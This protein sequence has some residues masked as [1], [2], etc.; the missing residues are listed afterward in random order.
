MAAFL[1]AVATSANRPPFMDV[2]I[3]GPDAAAVDAVSA[4]GHH[5]LAPLGWTVRGAAD[6]TVALC[7]ADV[8]VH[9]I[10]YGDLRGREDDEALANELG[11]PG[12]ETFGPAGLAAAVVPV[13]GG[14]GSLS[15]H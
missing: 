13:R 9:R 8:V 6:I 1:D 12:D 3:H 10:R 11:A 7:G 5:Q 14:G 2:T 15:I 4:Y